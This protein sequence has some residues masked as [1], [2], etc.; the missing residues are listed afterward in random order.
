MR[1]LGTLIVIL[2]IIISFGIVGM[3]FIQRS[4][5]EPPPSTL[6]LTLAVNPL[7]QAWMRDMVTLFNTSEAR[8]ADG[9]AITIRLNNTPTDDIDVWNKGIWN[10][11]TAPRLWMPSST[12][13]SSLS[14]IEGRQAITITPSIAK[15]PIIFVASADVVQTITENDTHPF[16]W[17]SIQRASQA[18]TW[19][20]FGASHLTGNVTLAFPLPNN[21]MEGLMVM[22]SANAHFDNSL[23]LTTGNIAPF[24][25]WFA[26]IVQSVPNFNTIGADVASFMASRGASINIGIMAECRFLTKLSAITN[27]RVIRV[28]YPEYPVVFDFP[29]VFL[30]HTGQS[31]E[32]W[33]IYEHAAQ[34]FGAWLSAP[35]QQAHLTRH[36]LRPVESIPNNTDELFRMGIDVGILYDAPITPALSEVTIS[37]ARSLITWFDTQR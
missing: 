10:S 25:Q 8:I 4:Q 7:A 18:G 34:R 22:F 9:Y 6:E 31:Q 15:T 14:N 36:G 20:N 33:A 5:P 27:N 16:D 24:T 32:D 23:T 28:T 26:P 21:T 37:R 30:R 13:S 11:Q 12:I 3:G 19:A 17:D 29:L 35:E 1:Q 2:F